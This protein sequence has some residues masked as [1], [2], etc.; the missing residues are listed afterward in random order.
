[1]KTALILIPSRFESDRAF[2]LHGCTRQVIEEDCLPLTP[3]SYHIHAYYQEQ[4]IKTMIAY[5]D[6]IYLFVDFGIDADMFKVIDQYAGKKELVYRRTKLKHQ[7]LGFILRDVSQRSGITVAELKSKCR[8][9]A[10][11]DVRAVY[12]RRCRELTKYS[13]KRIA[14][15]LLRDHATAMH[16][17]RLASN[18]PQIIELY[19]QIYAETEINQKAVDDEKDSFNSQPVER[20]V[21]PYR[22]MDEREQVVSAG[23]QFVR[24]MP[25]DGFGGGFRGYRPHNS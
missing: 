14:E 8:E 9:R 10:F 6:V 1:M 18:C 16:G 12:F 11:S 17:A 7:S 3:P 24:S 20:P 22:S 21:L 25:A 13:W 19:N 5:V 23:A 4:F 2:F 15:E